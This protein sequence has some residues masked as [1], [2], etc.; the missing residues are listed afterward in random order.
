MPWYAITDPQDPKLDE[1]AVQFKLHPLHIEDCRSPHERAKAE[2]NEE[3]GNYLFVILKIFTLP[4][5]TDV[6]FA[7]LCL[8]V[9]SDFLITV[10]DNQCSAAGMLERARRAGPDTKPGKL[11]YLIFDAVVDGYLTVVDKF[12][13]HI[14]DLQDRVLEDPRSSVLQEIFEHK[15]D[16]AQVRRLLVHTR[17]VCL[18]VQRE[19]DDLTGKDLRPFFRDIYDHITR[20]L[21]AVDLE[22]DMLTNTLDVYL[23]SVANRT[24]E[25]MKVLTVLSTVALPCLLIS[26]I[27]GMNIKGIP[28]LNSDHGMLFVTGVMATTTVILLVVLKKLRWL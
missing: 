28:F 9:S 24:N 25:V 18:F 3:N 21:D 19:A 22:R 27:Y 5:N 20:N 7:S 1:L 8:F 11:F 26:S 23:S 13:E 10:C 17:D 2:R 14:D 16:L 15:R 6:S 12:G 4:R